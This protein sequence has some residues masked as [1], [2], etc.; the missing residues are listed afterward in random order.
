V[1]AAA[2]FAGALAAG[3]FE[4]VFAGLFALVLAAGAPQPMRPAE[5]ANM[6]AVIMV[7]VLILF[8]VSP[9]FL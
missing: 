6:P 1:F 8:P 5:T 7:F 2:V 4:L 9:K 3:V